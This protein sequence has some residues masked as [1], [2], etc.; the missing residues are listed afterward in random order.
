MQRGRRAPLTGLLVLILLS[1]T[2][3]AGS[4][5]KP[6]I[7]DNRDIRDAHADLLAAWLVTE[8]EGL[9]FFVKVADG[10]DPKSNPDYLYG[11]AFTV[12]GRTVDAIVGYDGGGNL[13]TYLGPDSGPN[14][15]RGGLE[16]VANDLVLEPRAELGQPS[17]F[18]G[19]VPWG[20][21]DG[22]Q[23]GIVLDGFVAFTTR[24]E[25]GDGWP[26]A[27]DRASTIVPYKV[28]RA[29][30]LASDAGLLLVAVACALAGA[31][32]AAAL[33]VRRHRAA[34]PAP[35]EVPVRAE[36]ARP[37]FRLAP[38]TPEKSAPVEL[39]GDRTR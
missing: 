35:R 18:S 32:I 38:T 26:G 17:V 1:P 33:V 37:A 12:D 15:R 29:T 25:R 11:V 16:R 20:A 2:A 28:E 9:R 21:L 22:F 10:A 14:W 13:L 19:L 31:G 4:E 34:P 6:D 30:F 5:A 3:W 23:E 24:Y 8:E 7:V 39:H 27:Y 36:P